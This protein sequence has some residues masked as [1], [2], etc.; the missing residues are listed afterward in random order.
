M[1]SVLTS[2]PMQDEDKD[3]HIQHDEISPVV[4][5][6]QLETQRST[7]DNK[8]EDDAANIIREYGVVDFT[9]EEDRRVLRK[10]DLWVCSR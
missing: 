8:G 4:P 7:Y 6:S 2:P 1:T 3:L 5:T 9:I 10:I